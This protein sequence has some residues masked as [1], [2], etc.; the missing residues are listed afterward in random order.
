MSERNEFIFCAADSC[1]LVASDDSLYCSAHHKDEVVDDVKRTHQIQVVVTHGTTTA[2]FTEQR[3]QMMIRCLSLMINE[4]LRAVGATEPRLRFHLDWCQQRPISQDRLRDL[5]S[6]HIPKTAKVMLLTPGPTPPELVGTTVHRRHCKWDLR[7]DNLPRL[8][9]FF[10][11]LLIPG[12]VDPTTV[13]TYSGSW[14]HYTD[15]TV[16]KMDDEE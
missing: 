10:C 16:S 7:W 8:A 14:I 6:K 4:R 15:G 3:E 1:L 12:R 11:A 13:N 9:A 2:Y 5:L